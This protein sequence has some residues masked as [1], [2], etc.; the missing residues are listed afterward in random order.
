MGARWQAEGIYFGI[1][2]SQSKI[3]RP[4]IF[5]QRILTA[6]IRSLKDRDGA[7]FGKRKEFIW[8]F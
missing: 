7:P 5:L 8:E 4:W 2:E 1:L 3:F 6:L